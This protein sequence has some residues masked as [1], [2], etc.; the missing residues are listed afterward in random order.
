M[1]MQGLQEEK[2]LLTLMEELLGMVVEPFQ[3]K[4]PLKLIDQQLMQQDMLQKI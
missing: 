3:A 4:T 1:E 2:Y